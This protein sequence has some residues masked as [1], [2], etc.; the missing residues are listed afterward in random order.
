MSYNVLDWIIKSPN[1]IGIVVIKIIDKKIRLDKLERFELIVHK[2]NNK[3]RTKFVHI[4]K[5]WNFFGTNQVKILIFEEFVKDE[6]AAVKDLLNFLQINE[7]PPETVGEIH[8]EFQAPRGRLAY[9]LLNSKFIAKTILDFASRNISPN[10]RDKFR[11]N[12][13]LKHI[14]KPGFPDEER[15][16]LEKFYLNDVK[17]LQVLLRRKL[18]WKWLNK[19]Q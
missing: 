15:L 16:I 17:E 5:Y 4:K 13:L 7:D 14:D 8:N 10:I 9:R 19:Y 2:N 1:K 18:P 12:V 3:T 11:N 6:R